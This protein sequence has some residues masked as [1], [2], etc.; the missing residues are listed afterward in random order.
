[1]VNKMKTKL[2][3]KEWYGVDEE[4][5]GYYFRDLGFKKVSEILGL[6]MYELFNLNRID[7]IRAWEMVR[8]LYIFLNKNSDADQELEWNM[9]DQYFPFADWRKAHK[10]NEVRVVDLVMA[11]D[12]NER[13]LHK[14][15]GELTRKFYKSDEYCGRY[16]KYGS[17]YEVKKE[18]SDYQEVT[19]YE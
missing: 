8:T 2:N 15:F 17:I 5:V 11:F 16:Y 10:A 13:A 4:R 9:I 1:M 6:R 18:N 14:L 3:S 19:A 12:M 7:N